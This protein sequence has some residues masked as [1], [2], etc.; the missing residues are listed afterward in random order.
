ML[1]LVPA[2]A[3][4]THVP[5]IL[6]RLVYAS[7]EPSL[8]IGWDDICRCSADERAVNLAI[9]AGYIEESHKAVP[10]S[11]TLRAFLKMTNRGVQA[12]RAQTKPLPPDYVNCGCGL[13]F[14][15]EE[16]M[17]LPLVGRMDD[18]LGGELELR[19]CHCGSARAL[20]VKAAPSVP[21]SQG[22]TGPKDEDE[23]EVPPTPRNC[24][25]VGAYSVSRAREHGAAGG[26][27]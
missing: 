22:P 11:P 15:P 7:T 19:N 27:R 16:W 3:K 1:T 4:I 2:P 24:M 21:S 26:A 23:D 17:K 25:P 6:W 13:C 14:S 9:D 20:Q 10:P 12:L 18:G 5:A 8:P